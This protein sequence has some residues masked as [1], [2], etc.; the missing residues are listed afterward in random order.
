MVRPQRFWSMEYGLAL[1]T[2]IGMP[3]RSAYSIDCSRVRPQPRTGAMVSRSG[4]R[5]RVDNSKRTWSF[6]LPVQPWATASAPWARAAST[7]CLTMIGRDSDEISGDFTSY[8]WLSA[9]DGGGHS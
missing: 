5:A 9:G 4:A 2:V 7:R 6:P 8:L 3:H 1:V